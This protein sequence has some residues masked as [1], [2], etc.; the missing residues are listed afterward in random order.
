LSFLIVL[1]NA[2][3]F[4]LVQRSYRAVERAASVV[5][6]GCICTASG[7]YSMDRW[8]QI[9]NLVEAAPVALVGV[10]QGNV[11]QTRKWS[12]EERLR[13]VKD[14]VRLSNTLAAGRDPSLVVWPETA[15]P[16]YPSRD[17]LLEPVSEFVD[18]SGT[19]LL[20]GAPWFEVEHSRTSRL[21]RHYNGALLMEPGVGGFDFAYYKSHLVPFGEY[22]PLTRYLPFLAPLVEAA[23][24]FTPGTIEAPLE[25]GP[26]R[27]GVLICFESI[28]PDLGRAWVE[29][30]ANLLVN[31]TN[32][33]WYGKSS[34]PHQSWAMTVYRSVETR[35]SL[36]RSAN[37][38]ISGFIDPLGRVQGQSGLFVEWAESMEV[39]L[40]SEETFFV[41]TGYRFAPICGAAAG[42]IIVIVLLRRNGGRDRY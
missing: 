11:E 34:A 31:L 21:V 42:V 33:A 39:A 40:L 35:R 6:L 3:L 22:V 37:T 32:D 13:T 23:G 12:P 26:V 16:F 20:T 4:M 29:A 1:I 9:D 14:Y 41:R 17:D 36:V 2:T 28:F 19:V 7:W 8:H 15:L 5:L 24:D 18:A 30:G 27:A 10:A 38:G 25:A